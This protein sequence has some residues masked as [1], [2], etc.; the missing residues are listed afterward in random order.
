M[1]PVVYPLDIS[2]ETEFALIFNGLIDNTGR[3]VSQ[4]VS[5]SF[6]ESDPDVFYQVECDG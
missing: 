5:E 3:T 4:D 1:L 6:Q 2:W